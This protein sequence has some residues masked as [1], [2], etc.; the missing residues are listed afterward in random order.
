MEKPRFN[1]ADVLIVLLVPIL[2]LVSLLKLFF[3]GNPFVSIFALIGLL[4]F[5]EFFFR[6][7]PIFMSYKEL[8][9]VIWNEK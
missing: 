1:L 4:L 8:K 9:G 2:L 5:E 3:E 7:E 6:F